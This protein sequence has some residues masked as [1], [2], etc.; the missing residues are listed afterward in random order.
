[1]VMLAL[2]GVVKTYPSGTVALRNVSLNVGDGELL[3]LLGPSGCG[4]T[5]LLRLVAGLEQPTAGTIRLGGRAVNDEPPRRRDVALVFQRPALYPHLSARENL[6]FGLRLAHR[7]PWWRRL[8][9]VGEVPLSTEDVERITA[10]AEVL[11]L[12]GL[13]DR[14]PAEL[15][16]GEQQRV[17]LGRALVRRPGLLLLDEPLSNLDA[18]LRL[19][20]RRQ[21]LLLRRR[22]RATMIHVTHDQDEALNLGDRVAILDRGTLQQV[23]RPSL[24]LERPANRF[25]AGFLGSP[26][27]SLLDGELRAA[28]GRLEFVGP[29][30]RWRVPPNRRDWSA[31]SGRDVTLAVRPQE[32]ILR[33]VTGQS[34]SITVGEAASFATVPGE[35]GSFAYGTGAGDGSPVF[36]VRLVERHTSGWLVALEC[37]GWRLNALVPPGEAPAEGQRMTALPDWDRVCL[38]DAPTGSALSHGATAQ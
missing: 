26:P 14:R 17:A 13:L 31:V 25:V 5:T 16:G 35:G 30:G 27:R 22:F 15:S 33:P 2:E 34:E 12:V 38:F 7:G 1:M 20:M 21:L 32:V 28:D 9:P 24:L 29:G 37:D 23:D 4:K 10:A 8:L 6:A 11:G 18:Q 19:E 36:E 3:V